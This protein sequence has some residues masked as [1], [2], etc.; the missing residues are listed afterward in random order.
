MTKPALVYD[1]DCPF[2]RREA[3]RLVRWSG[4]DIELESFRTAGIIERHPGLNA[5]ACE[6]AIQLVLP[7][8]Q[9]FG[10]AHAIAR[11]LRQRPLLAPISWLYFLPGVRQLADGAYRIV[12]RNRFRLRGAPCP[13][14]A[15][16]RHPTASA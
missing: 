13:T 10:G 8:G 15:C 16:H 9:I 5:P 11:L 6:E 7:D 2:C 4:A 1:G 12:A 14:D 3:A